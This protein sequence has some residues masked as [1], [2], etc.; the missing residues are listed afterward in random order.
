MYAPDTR[1][2][3]RCGTSAAKIDA[4]LMSRII[5]PSPAPNSARKSI[6]RISQYGPPASGTSTSGTGKTMQP[7]MY[8]GPIPIRRPSR[9][10]TTEPISPPTAPAPRTIPSVAGRTCSE[11]TA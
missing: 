3:S 8:V 2:R 1:E 4:A 9:D 6:A 7:R 5:T 10:V 11:R